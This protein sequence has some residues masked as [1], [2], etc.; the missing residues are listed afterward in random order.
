MEEMVML[1][2]AV[3]RGI[4][5]PLMVGD[6]PMGSYEASNELAVQKRAAHGQENGPRWSSS[7]GGTSVERARAIIRSASRSWATWA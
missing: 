1:G 5:T 2:R 4:Q 6:M 3:R 7:R